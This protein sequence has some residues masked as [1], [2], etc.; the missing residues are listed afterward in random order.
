M[1]FVTG[2]TGLIGSHILLELVNKKLDFRAL[3]RKNSSLKITEKVFKFYNKEKWFNKIKWIE[4]DLNDL[5]SLRKGMKSCE[6]IIHAAAL[7]SFHPNDKELL[8]KINVDGTSNIINIALEKKIKKIGYISS[9]SALGRNEDESII[10]EDC[11]FVPTRKES[12]YG[13]SK[14]LAE[15]EVWRGSQEGLD[16][17]IINPTIVLGPGDWS[18]GSSQIFEKVNNGLSF[19]TGGSS[20]YIDVIDVANS[21]IELLFSDI[22][23]Q[24][25]IVSSGNFTFKQIFDL[26]ADKLNKPRPSIEVNNT[27]KEIAWRYEAVKSFFTLKRPLLTKET[28]QSAVRKR[29]YSNKKIIAAINYQFIPISKSIDKYSKW[30]VAE[31]VNM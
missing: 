15:Q 20:G 29:R 7:V 9:V 19:F 2:G 14:Y 31:S 16:V 10:N 1:I 13:L 11:F 12:K 22:V 30:F 4:G 6:Y 27:L 17:I 8:K 5:D 28:A 3:R 25:F 21:I 24:R 26:I 23:N 18:K